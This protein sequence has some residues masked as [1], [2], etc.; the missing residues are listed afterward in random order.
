MPALRPGIIPLRPLGLGDIYDGT[1]KL[2]RSNPK[3]VL[4]LSAVAA[5]LVAIPV[6]VGQGFVFGTM[7]PYLDESTAFG[8]GD[9]ALTSG[10]LVAQ[11]AGSLVSAAIS[12]VAV[13]VLTGVLTR[14]LGRAVFGGRITA[15]EAW[16]TTKSRLPA[17]F[18]VV[19]L[20]GLIMLVPAA[21]TVAVLAV[22]ITA[23]VS[24]GATIV[25]FLLM[26]LLSLAYVLFFRARFA[27]APAAV[28]LEGRGPIDAMRRSW[29]LVTGQFWRVLG[30]LVLTMLIVGLI[31]TV[32]QLPFTI[33][34]SLIGILGE[35]SVG[36]VVISSVLVAIAGMLGAML[37]YPLEAG[38]SGLLYADRRMRSE[39]F[40]LVLQTAAI[41][42][43]R[44]GWV[45]TSADELWHPSHSARS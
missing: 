38:V 4:G 8:A 28:V 19:A 15:Q 17:L 3:A 29:S 26:F 6:A 30:I 18:G 31:T 13:T 33:A 43:Q 7:T 25:V 10:S 20:Q 22:A 1:I 27:F 40:D 24:A 34:G 14:I 16:R 42:Q 32:L 36:T 44:Q 45:P 5:L 12:F 39:A 11:L 23:G 35:G 21:V 37:T 41:E 2:I 9:P